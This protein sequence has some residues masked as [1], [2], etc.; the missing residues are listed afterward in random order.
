MNKKLYIAYGSN[1]NLKQMAYRCPTAELIGTG[2]VK[3]YELQFKGAPYG[4]YATIGE[5]ENAAVP[6]AVWQLQNSDELKLDIYEGYPNN[7]YKK[8]ITVTVNDEELTAM[9]YIMNPKMDYGMPSSYY[10][11]VVKQGQEDCG[12]DTSVL[13]Q[14]LKD[15]TAK[16]LESQADETEDEG[17]SFG[18]MGM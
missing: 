15:S 12:L 8:D 3:N 13:E 6:V 2:T 5:K 11:K 10:Y 4:A 7:Y 9:V 18:E 17:V 16:Y 14:A 1:L